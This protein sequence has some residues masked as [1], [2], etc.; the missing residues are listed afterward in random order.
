MRNTPTR[1]LAG[2]QR[3]RH[4]HRLL[5]LVLSLN[6]ATTSSALEHYQ[7]D[8][9]GN[10]NQ[11]NVGVLKSNHT[12]DG[13]SDRV[14]NGTSIERKRQ[15]PPFTELELH[16]PVT[17][18]YTGGKTAQISISA[19]KG[20]HQQLSAEV[21]GGRLRISGKRFS[22][23]KAVI[24]TVSSA[25]LA[26]VVLRGSPDASFHGIR[27]GQFTLDARGSAD[28][29]FSGSADQCQYRVQ[30]AADIDLQALRCRDVAVN[31]Q[32]SSD[33]SV[34]AS[35]SIAGTVLG[36]GDLTIHGKPTSDKLQATGA[37]DI[38]YR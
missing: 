32:G 11:I 15:L 3:A 26:R 31:S 29:T 21:Q 6:V 5:A 9:T 16:I 10:I 38:H 18:R 28:A 7:Q 19:P 20:V 8:D 27:G 37:F 34:Y 30:G 4:R 2:E 22:T 14:S 23:R 12:G 25:N 33:I 36:A 35:T 17:L 24:V 13:D 1:T